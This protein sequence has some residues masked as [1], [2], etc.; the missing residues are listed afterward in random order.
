MPPGIG[1]AVSIPGC[2]GLCRAS[3]VLRN[4][5]RQGMERAA[6]MTV[7]VVST[8]LAVVV[9]AFCSISVAALY[10]VPW[11]WIERLRK[12][13]RPAGDMLFTLRSNVEKPAAALSTLSIVAKTAGAAVAGAAGATVF[14]AGETWL[15]A[16]AFTAGILIL[17]EVLPKTVG[18]A[19]SRTVSILVA[20]PVRY[21]MLLLFPVVWGVGLLARLVGRGRGDPLSS[22]EDLRAVVS[23]TRQEGIINPLEE[24]SIKNI[25]SLDHKTASDIMTPR[26]VV[27][28]LPAEMTVAEARGLGR[29]VWPHS[30]IPVFDDD[31]ENI[32]GIV[33]R[34]EVL[35]ALANDQDDARLAD[36]M[37]PVRFVL[38]TMPLD[39]VLVKFLESR[40]HL[41]VV[42]DEYGGVSGVVSLEDVLEE[43]LGKEIVDETDQVAD[44][45]EL[46]RS[47]REELLRQRRARQGAS[48]S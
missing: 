3:G 33:Y 31:P 30:R 16:A 24:L 23:L 15:F 1:A 42:L 34:R 12:D 36:L 22:E 39:R 9:S 7:L 32:V 14:G 4:G 2:P 18:V 17:G 43:I 11:S 25:L 19:Y 6:G 10:A 27:F 28:S 48:A 13:G 45:R 26:T 47:R 8:T 29:G 40:M 46:A 37:K 41:F 35:E 21:M 44:M 38:D 5:I 20:V